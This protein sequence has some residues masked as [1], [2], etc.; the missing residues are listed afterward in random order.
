MMNKTV[1]ANGVRVVTEHVPAVHSVSVGI[2]VKTGSRHENGGES[3]IAHFIEH[4][5]FKGTEKRSACEISRLID[6]VGGSINAFTSKEY[7]CFYVKVLSRHLA[8]AV[9]L[10]SDIFFKSVFDEAEIEKERNVI[11]QEISMVRDTPDDYIQDLFIQSYFGNHPLASAILGVPETVQQF[12]RNNLLDFFSQ[13]H[14][15]PQKIIISAAGNIVH[16]EVLSQVAK[17]FE[18][19]NSPN[20]DF[21][22][23]AFLPERKISYH[24]RELEQVHICLGTTG[25]SQND[26]KRYAL[27]IL[28]AILGGSMSSRLFQEIRE[29]RGLAYSVF[30]FTSSF[31]DTGL[32]GIYTGVKKENTCETMDVVMKEMGRLGREAVSEGEL[33]D[34]KEQ[35]KGNMLL[36]LESTDSR[37]SRIAR[38][39]MYY[40]RYVPIDDIIEKI[41][42]VEAEMVRETARE[43]FRDELFT[44][45]FLGPVEEKEIPEETIR[46]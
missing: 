6:S 4:M 45:T 9:D 13:Q 32:F 12:T 2:W 46:L 41:E 7:T 3:G 23:S 34:A 38:S 28:N 44:F 19:F 25:Y 11:F 8:L 18:Q 31:E 37:M 39:E 20:T 10:L 40:N 36:S 35:L 30:S 24:Y 26:D 27:Y 16:E 5:L 33:R 1:L 43:I 29:N 14:L 21:A 17:R 42:A 15:V 22:R